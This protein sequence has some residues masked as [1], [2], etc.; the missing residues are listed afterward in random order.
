[1]RQAIGLFLFLILVFLGWAAVTW[2][3]SWIPYG[4]VLAMALFAIVM[5][6]FVFSFFAWITG[7]VN[8]LKLRR[9]YLP[10]IGFYFRQLPI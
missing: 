1:M 8:A 5:A 9:A 6:A 10:M 2:V 7:M 4:F 3:I